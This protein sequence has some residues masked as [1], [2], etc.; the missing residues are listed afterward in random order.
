MRRALIGAGGAVAGAIAVLAG[1]VLAAPTNPDLAPPAV[2]AQP[3]A[4]PNAIARPLRDGTATGP[5]IETDYGPV[6]VRVTVKN[7]AI[8][9]IEALI[10]P[11]VHERSRWIAAN[12][13]PRL[14]QRI[15]T[16]QTADVDVM[17]G[18]TFTSSGYIGSLQ[19]AL[20]QLT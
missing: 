9:D 12:L 1:H 13:V 17:S 7:G 10:L 8:T 15:L 14:R 4:S 18:A 2:P 11:S 19:F 6:Q 3:G 16:A 5:R 20:D